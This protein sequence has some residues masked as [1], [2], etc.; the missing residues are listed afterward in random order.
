MGHHYVTII[1]PEKSELNKLIELQKSVQQEGRT[2]RGV[3]KSFFGSRSELRSKVLRWGGELWELET[4]D[5]PNIE[6][7][8]VAV[9]EWHT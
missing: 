7:G 5:H 3:R 2:I 9:V 6:R 1:R 4:R 8:W